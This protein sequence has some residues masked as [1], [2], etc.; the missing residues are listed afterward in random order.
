MS[1]I[2]KVFSST[3]R[4]V[5]IT[6]MHFRYVSSIIIYKCENENQCKPLRPMF[7]ETTERIVTIFF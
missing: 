2:K 3:Y 6:H 5:N 4:F 1:V 7:S